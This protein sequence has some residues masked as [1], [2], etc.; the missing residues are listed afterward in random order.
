MGA[1]LL[2]S[3]ALPVTLL[4]GSPPDTPFALTLVRGIGIAL[5]SLGVAYWLARCDGRSRAARGLV[6]AM[7]L[8]NT[9]FA[10][11]LAY[12]RIGTGLSGAA[13]W[14]AVL[15]HAALAVWC[16]GCLRS[17]CPTRA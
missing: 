7:L 8:Y 16:A 17:G 2:V 5:L 15:M 12:A 10:A 11:L 1:S 14:P 3:P 4:L 13:L 9:A 6:S